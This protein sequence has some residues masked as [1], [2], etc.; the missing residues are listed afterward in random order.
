MAEYIERD[1]VVKRLKTVSMP[2]DLYSKGIQRGVEHAVDIITEAPA[3]DVVEVV[4][5][6]DCKHVLLSSI[7]APQCCKFETP[8]AEDDF[9]SCGERRG[10]NAAD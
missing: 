1:A 6:K 4:R 9:C 8:V 3:A 7:W 10:N 5:C 2:D